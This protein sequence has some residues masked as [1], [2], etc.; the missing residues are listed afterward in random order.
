MSGT[1]RKS[2]RIASLFFVQY[3]VIFTPSINYYPPNWYFVYKSYICPTNIK[4]T[5]MKV[6]FTLALLLLGSA[7]ANAT[8][9]LPAVIGDN[10]VIQQNADVRL[11]GSAK[12]NSEVKITTSWGASASVKADKDGKFLT[13]VKSQAGS[14]DPQSITIS[15]KDG[16]VTLNN[17]L[18]GEVWFAGGQSNMEMPLRGF[19]GCIVKDGTDEAIMAG[20]F[21]GIRFFT[22]P[23]LHSFEDVTDCNSSWKTTERFDEVLNFSATAW[24]FARNLEQALNIPVGIVVCAYGG[25]RVESWMPENILKGY[26]DINC[27]KEGIENYLPDWERPLVAYNGM[28]HVAHQFTYKGIIYYQGCSNVGH[29]D[30][31]ADR[32]ATMVKNWRAEMKLGDI[33]FYYCEIA[34]YAYDNDN[35]DAINGALLRE[36]QFKALK[37]IPNSG[38]ISTNNAALPFEVLNIHPQLKQ[39]VGARLSYLALNKTYGYKYLCCEGP[40]FNG[41][42]EVKNNEA[43]IT[44]DKI[45]DGICRNYDIQGFEVAGDDKVFYP[46]DKVWI[47]W[48]TNEVV[49][50]SEKV[51]KPAAVRYCF[52]NFQIG[53]LI[54][55]NNLPCI[56]FRTDNWD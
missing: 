44:L 21:K 53:N 8:V 10:M 18:V 26:S 55:G 43:W 45:T 22:V 28:F 51:A 52:K 1:R 50:S 24:F 6:R 17:V 4:T 34:P 16:A 41:K 42:W 2:E 29:H 5:N 32:L 39:P 31:Y 46:A 30:T 7:F 27:S 15:D 40:E 48:Q 14:Y 9:K 19:G 56:P 54:G 47:H 25:S 11:W 23:K 37:L 3:A 33:P 49:V 20:R 36:A 35:P 12:A 13:T 38:M